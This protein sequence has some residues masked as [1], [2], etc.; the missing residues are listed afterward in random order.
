MNEK[1]LG[2]YVKAEKIRNAINRLTDIRFDDAES[3][4]IKKAQ[5]ELMVDLEVITEDQAKFMTD[6]FKRVG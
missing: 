3:I 6:M 4:K 2:G 5:V 1:I